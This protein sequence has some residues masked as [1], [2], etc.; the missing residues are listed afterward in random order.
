MQIFMNSIFLHKFSLEFS[1]KTEMVI[2]KLLK[3]KKKIESQNDS[4]I[5]I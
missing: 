3:K 2:F 1:S 4:G 5:I